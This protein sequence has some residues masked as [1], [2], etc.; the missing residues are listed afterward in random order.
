MDYLLTTALPGQDAAAV[1]LDPASLVDL[2]ADALRHLHCLP[3]RDCPFRY[4]ITDSLVEARAMLDAG[5]V[6]V[7]RLELENIGRAP[8]ELYAELLA[9]RPPAEAAVF[10]H[11][12]FCLPNLIVA[13]GRLSGFIDVG[14]AGLGDPHRD[15]ALVARSLGRNLALEWTQRFFARYGMPSPD[16]R[17]LRYFLLLDEFF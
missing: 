7:A 4:S 12:D 1:K 15:L 13:D 5:Q 16:P 11:G 8:A 6:D 17:S 3:I 2:L 9:A 10:T 14:R